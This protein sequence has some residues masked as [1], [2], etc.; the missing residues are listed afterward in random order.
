MPD[1]NGGQHQVAENTNLQVQTDLNAACGYRSLSTLGEQPL[2]GSSAGR[3]RRR[4]MG[5]RWSS[6]KVPARMFGAVVGDQV[7]ADAVAETLGRKRESS[8]LPRGCPGVPWS[9]SGKA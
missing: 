3:R 5:R 7:E 6:V 1:W 9:R 8:V 2:G 4:G